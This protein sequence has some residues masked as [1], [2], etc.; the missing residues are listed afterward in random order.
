[1]APAARGGTRAAAVAVVFLAAVL[2]PPGR[3]VISDVRD[4]IGTETVVGVPKAQ[5]ALFSL[6]AAGRVLVSAPTGTWVL[7]A[8]GSKRR[9]GDYDEASWSPQGLHAVAS[10][11]SQL[12]A[13]TP[14]GEVR[15]TLA[16][17]GVTT[18]LVAERIP[19]RVLERGEPPPGP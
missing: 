6:P 5:P 13:V 16:R 14:S 19:N 12:V 18:P 3:A 17:P 11:R 4:A 8:D 1:M 7:D 15:W 10:T 2:S 9:L